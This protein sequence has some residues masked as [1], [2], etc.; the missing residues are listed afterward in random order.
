MRLGTGA[1]VILNFCSSHCTEHVDESTSAVPYGAAVLE[2]PLKDMVCR[3]G[4]LT[5]VST[6]P[7]LQENRPSRN[8]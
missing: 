7:Q 4:G 8:A 6:Q 1:I 2:T 5:E 3:P